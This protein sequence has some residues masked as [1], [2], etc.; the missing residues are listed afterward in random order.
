MAE[1]VVILGVS[2]SKCSR[3]PDL[4][5]KD[6]A[7]TVVEG[8]VTDA[9]ISKEQ[10]QACYVSNVQ[11]GCWDQHLIKG[12]VWLDPMGIKG[13][14]IVN[15]ENACA[16]GHTALYLGYLGVA[17]GEHDCVMVLGVEKAPHPDREKALFWAGAAR[18]MEAP[19]M[20]DVFEEAAKEGEA[21]RKIG[22]AAALAGRRAKE[23]MNKS[24]LT[25]RQL[26]KVCVKNHF[27][28]SLNPYALFPDKWSIEQVLDSRIVS[29]PLRI[30]M[31]A[32]LCGG[33][34]AA[35]LCSPAFAR[36]YTTSPIYL[37]AVVLRSALNVG[38]EFLQEQIANDVYERA[39]IG[40][41]DIDI[42]ELWDTSCLEEIENY[43]RFGICTPD[44]TP[45]LIDKGYTEL[46]GQFPV[47]TSGGAEGRGHP[48]AAT[49]IAQ[50][51]ELVWQFRGQAGNRQV[52]KPL[53][54]AM[55][56]ISGGGGPCAAI[57]RK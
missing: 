15:T 44:E 21:K 9:G 17:A 56:H 50:I 53:K 52:D 16:S 51:T 26:A 12:E 40:P 55:S 37:L 42:F 4:N 19:P 38:D 11:G 2:M 18:D 29:W 1:D 27:N 35:I 22:Y 6:L 49:A 46:T 39:A 23:Y 32:N 20:E 33:S 14:P 45:A 8:A 3:S 48:S 36:R 13:L 43:N 25:E 5:F 10:I 28:A 30:P 34:G 47:N 57:I 31:M 7:R 24:G 41:S 54:A